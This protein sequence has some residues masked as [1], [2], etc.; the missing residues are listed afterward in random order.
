MKKLALLAGLV[1][2]MVLA[3]CSPEAD[4]VLDYHNAVVDNINPKI[5]QIPDLYEK[6]WAAA[7]EDEAIEVFD[8]E[9]IPLMD[10]IKAYFDKQEVEHDVAKEYHGLY[11]ELV[12]SMNDVVAKEKEY[13]AALIDPNTSEEDVL[14]IEEELNELNKVAEDND[15]A[16]TDHWESLK[17]EYDF[18]D[19]EE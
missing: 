2:M 6:V 1:L 16:V 4:E 10:E 18:V 3:A 14:A 11:V 9:L 7:T 19:E 5:E 12:Q 15:T 13:L 17:E 8:N